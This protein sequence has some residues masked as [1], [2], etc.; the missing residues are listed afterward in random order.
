MKKALIIDLDNTLYDYTAADKVAFRKLV[1]IGSKELNVSEEAFNEA[2]LKARDLVQERHK[3]RASSHNRMLYTQMTAEILEKSPMPVALTLYEIYWQTFFDSMH[4]FEGV[5][6]ALTRLKNQGIKLA[7]CTDMLARVQF[8][9][10]RV[11]R[12][13][14][15]FDAIVTSE[16]ARAEKPSAVPVQMLL[17]KL[18]MRTRE[19]AFI[20]D[21]YEKDVLAA[22]YSGLTPI[23]F[24]G[25]KEK[26]KDITIIDSWQDEKLFQM[27]C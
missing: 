5:E 12:I 14:K 3:R 21:G 27:F 13:S 23:W 15:Y 18:Q 25:N 6:E 22:K 1:E 9:K 20:G 24:K 2:Y 10:I 7:V 16:E 11:L 26:A 8:Q 17:D 4:L 19:V